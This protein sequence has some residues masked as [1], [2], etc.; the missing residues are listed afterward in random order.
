MGT[1]VERT[2]SDGRKAYK[3]QIILKR[4]GEA[5]FRQSRQFPRRST[6]RAWMER[7]E[8]ELLSPGGIEKAQTP[9]A[10]LAVAIDRY[11]DDHKK[12]YGRSKA[13]V[14]QRLKDHPFSQME[15]GEITSRHLVDLA[16]ELGEDRAASTVGNYLSHLAPVFRLAR[17]A[18]NIDLDPSAIN[19]ALLVCKSLGLISKSKRRDRR[20]TFDE[21]DRLLAHYE[22]S[23]IRGHMPMHKILVFAI[24][25]TRRQDE[26]VRIRWKDYEPE[27]NRVLVRDMK[28]PGEKIGNDVWCELPDQ[29]IQVIASM[30]KGD[31]TAAI[32]PHRANNISASFIRT[33]ALLGIE[34]LRF[35]DLR[36]EG[37]SRL[38][39]MGRTIPQVASV[40][41]HRSW[42]SL[43]RYSHMRSD[44][45]RYEAWPWL[46]RVT[47]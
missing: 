13:Q 21:L 10:T 22:D 3:A 17:P 25:S 41:G 32:F 35:H 16:R 38:F 46:D 29:A 20:P 26:I 33:C 30:P 40:S 15:C 44:G 37:V 43:Q 11:I 34:D 19:D 1:I 7:R 2:L 14:L 6:A 8:K 31:E 47:K 5:T 12:S 24:F 27:H 28:N 36:H 9:K 4:K 42:Q 45:D 18:W 23:A 39:E